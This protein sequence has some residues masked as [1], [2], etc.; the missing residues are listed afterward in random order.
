MTGI[1]HIPVIILWLLLAISA[2]YIV[3]LLRQRARDKAQRKKLLGLQERYWRGK[4]G[5]TRE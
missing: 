5:G 4:I 1:I 3:A 2:V